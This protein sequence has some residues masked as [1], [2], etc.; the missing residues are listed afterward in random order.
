MPAAPGRDE[1]PE[2]AHRTSLPHRLLGA[3]DRYNAA[4]P[5]D[6]ERPPPPLDPAAV[7]RRFRGAPDVGSGTGDP[8][9]PPTARADEG[10]GVAPSR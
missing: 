3:L 5:W 7:P 2:K 4:R 9:R 1:S 8:A 6:H 10:R